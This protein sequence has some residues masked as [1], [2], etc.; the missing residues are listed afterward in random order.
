MAYES[1]EH[2]R[3]ARIGRIRA[4][5]T[6]RTNRT[7]AA[8]AERLWDVD[9]FVKSNAGTLTLVGLTLGVF[10]SRRFFVLPI[11]IAAMTLQEALLD[12]LESGI[13][14]LRI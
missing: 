3:A 5:K 9:R 8:K 4:P 2:S 10:V 12:R 14:R 6:R 1:R 13:D 11:A 7:G